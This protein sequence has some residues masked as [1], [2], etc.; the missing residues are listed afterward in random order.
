MPW[1]ESSPMS[2]RLAFIQACLDRRQPVVEICARFGIS[3]KTGHKWIARFRGGGVMALEARSHAPLHHRFHVAPEVA[4]RIVALRRQH[5]LWRER[6]N[7][8][9]GSSNRCQRRCGLPAASTIGELLQRE[10]LIRSR[11]RRTPATRDLAGGPGAP[12]PADA[13]NAVWT[14]DFKGQFRLQLRRSLLSAHRARPAFALPLALHRLR[15]DGR[16]SW[17]APSFS[18]SFASMACPR[19][20]APTTASRSHSRMRWAAWARSATGGFA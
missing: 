3:E 5:P 11:R 12:V 19:C 1:P 6:S 9:T 7:C 20:C 14:A 13:S 17:P 16:G 18:G 4:A 10:G 15:H 8:A 2:E